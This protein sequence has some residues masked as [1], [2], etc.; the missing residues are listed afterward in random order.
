MLF[1]D[2]ADNVDNVCNGDIGYGDN[3]GVDIIKEIV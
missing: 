1:F 2:N 3:Y